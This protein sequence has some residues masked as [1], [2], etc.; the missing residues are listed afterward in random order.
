[1]FIGGESVDSD[2]RYELRNPATGE[3]F[4]TVAKGGIEHADRAVEN[5]RAA[6]ESGVWSRKSPEERAAVMKRVADRL[7]TDFEELMEAE[8]LANGATVRQ[9]GGFHVGLAS[10]HFMHFAEL[11]EKF[12][13]VQQ[14]PTVNHPT[15]SMNT[16]RYEP[17]RVPAIET[18]SVRQPVI[19]SLDLDSRLP[20]AE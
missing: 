7:A 15:M 1:M 3:V 12:Q 16:I 6:F 5:A 10:P 18:I 2:Q 14:V 13:Y 9:A 17:A 8:T 19:S 20:P 11:A 4:A